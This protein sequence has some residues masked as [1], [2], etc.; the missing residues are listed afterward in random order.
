MTLNTSAD[1]EKC[2]S[3]VAVGIGIGE[4]LSL[5]LYTNDSGDNK[6]Y[7]SVSIS[8]YVDKEILEKNVK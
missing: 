7:V 3:L 4:K 5:S 6:Y 1:L 2:K 8:Y